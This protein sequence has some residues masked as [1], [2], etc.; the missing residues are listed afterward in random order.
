MAAVLPFSPRTAGTRGIFRRNTVSGDISLSAGSAARRRRY[1]PARRAR[2]GGRTGCAGRGRRAR[3]CR[4]PPSRS[5]M[6]SCVEPGRDRGRAAARLGEHALDLGER[7]AELR[8][9]LVHLRIRDLPFGNGIT[10]GKRTALKPRGGRC[11]SKRMPAGTSIVGLAAGRGERRRVE[12][13]DEGEHGRRPP[14]RDPRG[15]T[16]PGAGRV[17]E[18]AGELRVGEHRHLMLGGQLADRLGGGA[19]ALGDA[20]SAR[21][22]RRA[23][24]AGRPRNGSGWSAPRSP[25][26]SL[27]GRNCARSRAGG[28]GSAALSS[29]EPSVCLCSSF[30]SCLVILQAPASAGNLRRARR[31]SR[32]GRARRPSPARRRRRRCRHRRAPGGCPARVRP[33]MPRVWPNISQTPT[34]PSRATL[35]IDLPSS[36]RPWRPKMRFMPV[37]GSSLSPLKAKAPV[38]KPSEPSAAGVPTAATRVSANRPSKGRAID[39]EQA[40]HDAAR[41]EV[42]DVGGVEGQPVGRPSR[43]SASIIIGPASA[44]QAAPTSTTRAVPS[45]RD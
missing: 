23:G 42:A 20:R 5:S 30:A 21:R 44:I 4:E 45:S 25:R 35:A 36:I 41:I 6:A 13:E 39:A 2:A 28:G 9:P 22:P 17:I 1:W 33:T 26:R 32:S 14:C 43:C 38:R 15:S 18:R 19:A 31:S 40:Q 29:G 16:W 10:A 8:R 11:A 24:S 12:V 7:G 27:C 37:S 34:A 3:R